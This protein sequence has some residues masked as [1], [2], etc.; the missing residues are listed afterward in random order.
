MLV[1]MLAIAMSASLFSS[2]SLSPE[3]RNASESGS[4]SSARRTT[5]APAT[6]PKIGEV[7]ADVFNDEATGRETPVDGGQIVVR[8]NAEPDT[9]SWWLSTGDQYSQNVSSYVHTTLLRQNQE[10]FEFEPGLAERWIEE[11]VL[12]RKDGSKVRGTL[13][14]TAANGDVS[15]RTP[16]GDTLRLPA[17]Q[18][19]EVHRKASFTF[20]LRRNARFHDGKP[21]TAADVK[22]SFDTIKNKDVDAP[23]LQSYFADME[24]CEVL[25]SH[26]VRITYAKQYWMA[27][28]NIGGNLEVYPKHI[29]DPDNLSEKDPKAFAKRFNESEYHRSPI[30]A[31]TYRFDRW[32][33]GLQIVL[34]RN[35]DYWD[36]AHRGHLDRIIFRFISDDVAALQALKNGEVDFLAG[37]AKP[38]QYEGEMSDK[39][40]L[41]RFA[42]VEFYIGGYVW[43][44]WN[45]RRPPFNDVKVRQ[46]MAYGSFNI[47]EF[48]DQ[49]YLGHAVQVTGGQHYLGP[50]YNHDVQPYPFDPEHAKQLLLEAGWYD[51]DGDGLRDKDGRAFRFEW[52]IPSG[53]DIYRRRA[54]VIKENLRKIG[55]DMTIRELEWA[56][57]IQNITDRQF[58]ACNLGWAGDLEDDP[59][60]L[61]HTSQAENRGDNYV[62]WGDA[63]RAPADLSRVPQNSIRAA[64]LPVHA[65]ARGTRR[66]CQALSRREVVSEAARLRSYRMVHP[67]KLMKTGTSSER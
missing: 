47:P 23:S 9:L 27:L 46:A 13:V 58:D 6:I 61:W 8:F 19:Q 5:S 25:D 45:M 22:F 16:A 43:A 31:G 65:Y 44:G 60:Q 67:E 51:R 63:E 37:R 2:C 35:D 53:N 52:L 54:A 38:E 48:L 49:V 40:F 1:G 21:L 36:P 34:T 7:K 14:S 17:A 28:A 33:T 4:A 66:L 12:V 32:D 42:R 39:S 57:F 30:G 29:F 20:F 50:A 18:I 62:G 56:T 24:S 59:Y 3:A 26:T 10:T 11:D 41:E 64:A 55:I 15:F